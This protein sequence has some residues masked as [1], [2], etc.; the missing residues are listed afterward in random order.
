MPVQR[1]KRRLTSNEEGA[2]DNDIEERFA[3]YIEWYVLDDD[4]SG[5]N[6]VVHARRPWGDARGHHLVAHDRR[7]SR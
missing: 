4:R 7:V 5:Y 6:L 2:T 3:F 1:T